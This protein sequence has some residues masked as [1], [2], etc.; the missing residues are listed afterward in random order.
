MA[1]LLL[2]PAAVALSVPA[3]VLPAWYADRTRQC[4]RPD[5]LPQYVERVR[6]GLSDR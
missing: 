3:A 4:C 2:P 6:R 1:G 5:G